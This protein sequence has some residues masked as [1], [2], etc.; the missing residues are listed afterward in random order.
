MRVFVLWLLLGS[1]I[2]TG[3]APLAR[4]IVDYPLN[5]SVFPP[6]TT[7]PTS[8]WR[9]SDVNATTWLIDITFG[10]RSP[11]IRVKSAGERLH[12]GNIDP[13]AVSSSN[14]ILRLTPEQ[15]AAHT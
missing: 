7:P 13:E 6:E 3:T 2:A 1:Y 10:G 5:G 15:G 9:D 12:I 4:I 11:A 14:E 8:I